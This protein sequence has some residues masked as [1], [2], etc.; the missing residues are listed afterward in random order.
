MHTAEPL[1]SDPGSFEVQ[2][3]IEKFKR[4]TSP[5][6]DQI[7]AEF[8]QAGGNTLYSENHKLINSIWSKE[9]LLWQWKE[10]VIVPVYKK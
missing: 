5:V 1:I 4:Y 8:I 2:I 7:L 3:A 10:P 9:E 6:I